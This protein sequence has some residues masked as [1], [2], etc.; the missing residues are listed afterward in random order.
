[1]FRGDIRIVGTLTAPMQHADA[2]FHL[3]AETRVW[4]PRQASHAVNVTGTANI[5]RAAL[6]SGVRRLVHVST[7]AVY[8]KMNGRPVTEHD[9]L[10]PLNDPYSITK[11]EADMLVQRMIR[12]EQLPAVILRP[13]PFLG[14]GD[15]H[16]FGRL[17]DRVRAGKCIIVGSGSNAV[18]LVY[19]SDLVQAL[20]LALDSDHAIGQAY[21]I[22]SD[23]TMTQGQYLSAIAHDIG[24]SPPHIHVPYFALYAAA[25]AAERISALSGYRI[26][27]V[28]TR[29]GVKILGRDNSISIDKARRDLGY[30]PQVSIRE[31]VRLTAAWYEQHPGTRDYLAKNEG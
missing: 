16:N 13:G 5:C 22:S 11:A 30:S 10:V 2:V 29:H 25:C 3:A 21:N 14:P 19:I 20:L 31:A 24:V 26:P 4:G 12:D 23:Q 1:V 27:P 9:P 8:K 28:I 15:R 6:M 17:A 7:F 18:P